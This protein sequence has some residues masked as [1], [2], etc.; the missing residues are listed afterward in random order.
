MA[1]IKLS[2]QNKTVRLHRIVCKGVIQGKPR[3]MMLQITSDELRFIEKAKTL[4]FTST[5]WC[6]GD[7]MKAHLHNRC[8]SK[9]ALIWEVAFETR[10]VSP[11]PS[12]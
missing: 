12:A 7:S 5:S 3:V 2:K 1:V 11:R 8:F 4:G 6:R 10:A 9:A